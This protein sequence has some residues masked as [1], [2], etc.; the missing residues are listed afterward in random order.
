MY[1]RV[2]GLGVRGRQRGQAGELC[3]Q[4]DLQAGYYLNNLRESFISEKTT[5]QAEGHVRGDGAVSFSLFDYYLDSSFFLALLCLCHRARA[6]F[7]LQC[8]GPS[9]L[10]ALG[11][12]LVACGLN[13][14]ETWGFC[15]IMRI[16]PYVSCI[17]GQILSHWTTTESQGGQPCIQC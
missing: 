11:I 4:G 16:K 6:L 12:F 10:A 3:G 17:G 7:W 5:F 8:M 14:P 1:C 9:L 13:C 15:S 2:E